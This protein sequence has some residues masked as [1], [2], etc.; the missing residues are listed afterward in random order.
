MAK[1]PGSHPTTARLFARPLTVTIEYY[2]S[3]QIVYVAT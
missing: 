3:L 2:D 1:I